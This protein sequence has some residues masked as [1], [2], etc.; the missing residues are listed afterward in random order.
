MGEGGGILKYSAPS[1]RKSPS[2]N[3]LK[4]LEHSQTKPEAQSTTNLVEKRLKYVTDFSILYVGMLS[5][6]KSIDL[7]SDMKLLRVGVT[8]SVLVT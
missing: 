5:K 1:K 2:N 4:N 7:T 3:L 6:L 8:I